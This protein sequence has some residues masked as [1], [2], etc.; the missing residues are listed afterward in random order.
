MPTP[1]GVPRRPRRD[2]ARA[3]RATAARWRRRRARP[4]DP[5]GRDVRLPPRHARPAAELRDVHERVVAELL[6]GRRRRGG[7]S[8]ARRGRAGRA[9]APRA[10][11]R[12][13]CSP[14]PSPTI[15]D[16]TRREL[17]IVRAA[18]EAHARYGPAAITTYII[19]KADSV[20][21]PA[22]GQSAAQGSRA[23]GGPASRRGGDHGRAAVRDDRRSRGARPRS[24]ATG[25]RCPRSPR[26][27]AARG[28]Q[29]VMVGYSDSNKDGG[30]LTSVWSLHQASRGARA[31]VRRGRA[32][33]C[34]CSTAAA[35]RSGAA[36]ARASPRSAPSRTGTVQGRIRITEQGEV[37]AAKYGTRESAAANLEAMAS[38]TLLASL[39]PSAPRADARRASTRRWTQ[40]SA[41]RLRRLS[42]PGLR[43]RGLPRPSSAR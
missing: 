27:T 38:A 10:R 35:A 20:S 16:E 42:R 6:E 24:C 18:A 13:G 1:A 2:R 14:A 31:G 3:R 4:A 17:A 26:S 40:I 19:S 37:I 36:A 28:H 33:A 23:C 15:R 8:G 9:A 32:S 11:R 7:L 5:R 39:E 25:S 21:R 22:R 12:R 41:R 43:D 34:S 30:Y 29:E